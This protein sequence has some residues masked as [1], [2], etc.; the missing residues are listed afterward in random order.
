MPSTSGAGS[1]SSSLVLRRQLVGNIDEVTDV[2][3]V[4]G[5]SPLTPSHIAV[6]S[7]C[8]VI[9]CVLT[10]EHAFLQS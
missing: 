7:N 6:A 3:L 9:R 5:A 2:R 4:G 10:I 8:E 1:S